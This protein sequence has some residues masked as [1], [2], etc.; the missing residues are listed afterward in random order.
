MKKMDMIQ[1]AALGQHGFIVFAQAKAIDI[2]CRDNSFGNGIVRRP[3]WRR[4][5]FFCSQDSGD[6]SFSSSRFVR[7]WIWISLRMP[8]R[9]FRA[10]NG[11]I[12]YNVCVLCLLGTS[13]TAEF[14]FTP[15][16][17]ILPCNPLSDFIISEK[18]E[19]G[20]FAILPT[21]PTV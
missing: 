21:N 10:N 12:Y 11:K 5:L 4:A 20:F 2:H 13:Q 8:L 3:N 17:M 14:V 1:Q 19:S 6:F 15:T 16:F 9:P 18:S 7:S